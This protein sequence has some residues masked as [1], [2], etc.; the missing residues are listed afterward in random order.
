MKQENWFCQLPPSN[1]PNNKFE[2][3]GEGGGCYLVRFEDDLSC[4][5]LT[6]GLRATFSEVTAENTADSF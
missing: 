6:E 2:W 4:F 3:G 5:I 1:Y